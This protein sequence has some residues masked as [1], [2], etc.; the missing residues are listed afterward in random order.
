MAGAA[1]NQSQSQS[2]Y[3]IGLRPGASAKG[4]S[5]AGLNVVTEWSDIASAHV[6]ATPAAMK[7]LQ[8]NP[9]VEYVEEDLAR[10]ALGNLYSDST[11]T[12]G[13]Q[14]VRAP[15]AWTALGHKGSG[16]KVCVLDT[17]ID[18]NQPEFYRGG[19]SIVK[20]YK[21]FTTSTS[22][23]KDIVGHGSHVAGTIAGQL[24]AS[25]SY[26]GVAP[27]VDLYVAKVLGDDGS[28]L[29]SWIL[30][31]VSW[32]V[33][34]VKANVLSMSLG[35]GRYSKTEDRNY[36]SYYSKGA[37]IIAAAGNNGD[38][39]ISYPAGYS[40]VV[41]VAA[42]DENLVRASFSQYNSDVELAG[43]GVNTLSSVPLGTGSKASVSEGSTPYKAVG[44]EYSP[45]GVVTGQLVECG[46]ADTTTS[47]TNKPAS[48]TWVALISRGTIAFADKVNNVVAQGASGAII[49]NN[50]TAL[51]DDAGS[52]TL[53][54]AG[55]WIPTSSVSYNSGVAIRNG[56]LGTGN[57]TLTAWDY[58]Y[59][60]GTSMATPHVSAVAALAW[61]A[62]PT[63]SN[64]TIRTVLQSTAKNL[65]PAGRDNEYGY[66]LVQADAAVNSAK[67][68]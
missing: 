10:H 22:G 30:N 12:W 26:I 53:G 62:K 38:R 44:L 59:Y 29:S 39:S 36:A 48:G 1:P 43:P 11:Y 24:N 67:T 2:S 57:V 5:I 56:G 63:L 35:G 31:G 4:L 55:N 66:G 47:C 21:N 65:G 25:G 51:P 23:I 6:M 16:R 27:D 18:L 64:G 41:S 9:N 60:Q 34:T 33:D 54:A 14:A 28:G 32:C 42:V 52:F 46:L 45:N 68:K 20:G 17:G 8:N 19:V 3:L 15:E 7:A 61:S 40:S 13:L 37:L 49:T 58:A 50:D